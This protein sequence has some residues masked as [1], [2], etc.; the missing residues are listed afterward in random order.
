MDY[1]EGADLETIFYR[2]VVEHHAQ[3]AP[4]GNYPNYQQ[5][6]LAELKHVVSQL[7]EFKGFSE[8]SIGE[9]DRQSVYG[10]NPEKLYNFLRQSG[11]KVNPILVEKLQRTLN[12]FHGNGLY[13]NDCHERNIILQGDVSSPEVKIAIVDF[14]DADDK[15]VEKHL[16]DDYLINR[17][18]KLTKTPQEATSAAQ[19][20]EREDLMKTRDSY[21]HSQKGGERYL[22]F[23][24]QYKHGGKSFLETEYD[25]AKGNSEVLK[26]YIML[27]RQLVDD[28]LLPPIEAFN[29]L[30]EK[31]KEFSD[32]KAVKKKNL[33]PFQFNMLTWYLKLFE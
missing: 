10:E 20:L 15:A 30:Q 19:Q 26:I 22:D 18:G 32:K 5:L 17:L 28:S 6:P 33:K 12:L 29:L 3:G 9:A 13:H 25:Y 4:A 16:S 14:G 21:L 23:S 7:L 2:W 24:R 1:I 11:F 27:L 31:I 8:R